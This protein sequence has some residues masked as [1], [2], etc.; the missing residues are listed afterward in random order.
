MLQNIRD[1]SQ[2]WL[3][4]TIV[5]V[6][7][8]VF[9]LWGIHSY[10][11]SSQPDQSV[12]KV[13]GVKISRQQFSSVYNRLKQAQ[14]QHLGAHY[15]FSAESN[16]ILKENA[17]QSMIMSLVVTQAAHK[18]GFRVGTD[19]I[20][21]TIAQMPAFQVNGIFSKSLFDR[22]LNNML[23]SVNE[24]F[25]ELRSMILADQLKYGIVGTSFVLSDEAHRIMQLL[26]QER[27]FDYMRIPLSHFASKIHITEEME[28]T[29]YQTHQD[30][31]KTKDQVGVE[32]VSLSLTNLMQKI[33]PTDSELQTYYNTHISTYTRPKRWKIDHIFIAVSPSATKKEIKAAEEK[34]DAV[35]QKTQTG[36][37]FEKLAKQ[38]SD[39]S[40]PSISEDK[41]PWISAMELDETWRAVLNNLKPNAVSEPFK[42]NRGFEIVKMIAIQKAEVN[43]Y[44]KVRSEVLQSVR[45][46]KAQQQFADMQDQLSNI[47]YETPN[48]LQPVVK[49]LKLPLYVTGLFTKSGSSRYPITRNPKIIAAAFDDDAIVQHNNS[50]PI[51]LSDTEVIV[52]R[53]KQYK[54]ASVKPF[55]TV[56]AEI[57]KL[58]YQQ[59]AEEMAKALADQMLKGLKAK[60]KPELLAAKFH[61]AWK[62]SGYIS[63][64][65]KARSI[66][67]TIIGSVFEL[68]RPTEQEPVN[69]AIQLPSGDYV[70]VSLL[71]V[72][73]SKTFAKNKIFQKGL[74]ESVG[75]NAYQLYITY[76]LAHAKI[77]KMSLDENF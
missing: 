36:V 9:A 23:T 67:S 64:Q 28:K 7:T 26:D 71:N 2:G 15:V 56:K 60:Q 40:H 34:A 35:Y 65:T 20:E 42:T 13:N 17:L 29:Y 76:S 61:L 22:A 49:Q 14:R 52:L 70:I 4:W 24:F 46:E 11:Y 50:E 5:I 27:Q 55:N 45:G 59:K 66:D 58:L 73:F 57:F 77:K 6:I 44:E 43:S 51:N 10:L 1:K 54:P 41:M 75:L 12:A 18:N 8:A 74:S 48:S 25:A 47:T 21:S 72:R 16:K 31:F 62:R 68:P 69:A 38:Y 33:H 53:V 39:E 30:D 3:T 37:S 32:Y 19:L 63:A